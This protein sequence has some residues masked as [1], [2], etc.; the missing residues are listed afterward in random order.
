[1]ISAVMTK[2]W[3]SLNDT[4]SDMVYSLLSPR[5]KVEHTHT[6]THNL[7]LNIAFRGKDFQVKC[8]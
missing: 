5:R 8:A 6:H 4:S 2:L 1:M 3:E 7:N